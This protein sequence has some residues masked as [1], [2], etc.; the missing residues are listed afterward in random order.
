MTHGS[1]FEKVSLFARPLTAAQSARTQTR[2]KGNSRARSP[3]LE[4]GHGGLLQ[5]ALHAQHDLRLGHRIE[6]H[7]RLLLGR[8]ERP[9]RVA[10]VLRISRKPLKLG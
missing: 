7:D 8:S 9:R 5:P 10:S 2:P 3:G 4:A 6:N 1:D